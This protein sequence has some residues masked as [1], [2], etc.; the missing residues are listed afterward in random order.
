MSAAAHFLFTVAVLAPLGNFSNTS[1][2]NTTLFKEI[3]CL[4]M[5][6]PSIKTC[7]LVKAQIWDSGRR[8]MEGGYLEILIY[9]IR[10]GHSVII[11]IPFDSCRLEYH[12]GINNFSGCSII[13]GP[14]PGHLDGL[15]ILSSGR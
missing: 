13:V 9:V 10:N 1:G 12:D 14:G 15:N 11:S 8:R 4:L 7:L 5:N 2:V 3:A 6:G